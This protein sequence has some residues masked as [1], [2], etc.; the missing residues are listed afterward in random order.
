MVEDL[1]LPHVGD[2]DHDCIIEVWQTNSEGTETEL[3]DFVVSTLISQFI[4]IKDPDGI[5]AVGSPFASSFVGTGS[6]GKVHVVLPDVFTG[7]GPW[8]K[9]AQLTFTGPKGPFHTQEI[10]FEVSGARA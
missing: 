4:I 7:P 3:V 6:D 9:Q 1:G 10:E 5:P 8:T 2:V